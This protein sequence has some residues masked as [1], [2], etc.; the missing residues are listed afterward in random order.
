MST[1]PEDMEFDDAVAKDKRKYCEHMRENLIEDQ[2]ITAAF[3]AEDPLKPRTIRIMVFILHLILYF[4]VNGFF[5]SEAFIDELYNVNEEDE[6]FFSY[7]PRSIDKIIYTTLVSV[8]VGIITGFFFVDEKKL[9]GILRREKDNTKVLKEKVSEFMKDLK[10]RYIAF[11]IVVSII[12]ILS[13]F[14]LLCFN[15]VYPYSQVEWIKSSITIFIIM[16]ILSLLKCILETSMRFLS[17]KFNS[18][19]LYK[20]SKFLD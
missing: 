10:R 2:L 6:N 19:K 14:Y 9:K 5:F 12:L 1:S 20:I 13:F 15:Y 17:Y 16:Q 4:V 7:L 18:E 8:V 3:V 11:I